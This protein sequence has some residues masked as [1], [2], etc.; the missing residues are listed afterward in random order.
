MK[1]RVRRRSIPLAV[2]ILAGG[3]STRMGRDKARLRIEG[4]TMLSRVRAVAVALDVPVRVI[5]KDRV[6]RCGPLGG[7][8]TALGARRAEAELFL[9]CDMPFVTS[10]LLR[11]MSVRL[12]R[13]RLAVFSELDG[14]AGFPFVVRAGALEIVEQQIAAGRYSLQALADSLEAARYRVPK[15]R[16]PELRNINTPEELAALR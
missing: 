11:L 9:A 4:R 2:S 3:L 12:G 10:A 15:S 16:R 1:A 13:G 8:L 14:L 7:V 5:R 6:A